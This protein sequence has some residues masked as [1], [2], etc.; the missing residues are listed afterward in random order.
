MSE[1]TCNVRD[2]HRLRRSAQVSDV[3]GHRLNS[4]PTPSAHPPPPRTLPKNTHT[5]SRSHSPVLCSVPP[6]LVVELLVVV[7]V[8]RWGE[9]HWQWTRFSFLLFFFFF[10]FSP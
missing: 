7:L 6:E 9:T 4:P 10:F 3:I 2:E 8:Y 5:H 1:L